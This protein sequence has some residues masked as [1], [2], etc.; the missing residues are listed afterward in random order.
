MDAR[1]PL[2]GRARWAGIAAAGAGVLAQI[3]ASAPASS[4][5]RAPDGQLTVNAAPLM[6]AIVPLI[7]LLFLIP[8]VVYGYVA[9]TFTSHRDVIKGMS[10][11]MG[12][13]AYYLVMSFFAAQFIEL[14]NKSNL[15]ALLA[16]KGAAG[17]KALSLSS[18]SRR[19]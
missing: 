9:G 10:K 8:G 12:T 4:P 15:G 2:E 3:R 13:M 18:C 5:L 19:W 6:R 7:F 17:L 11:T 16:L 1:M 14:F